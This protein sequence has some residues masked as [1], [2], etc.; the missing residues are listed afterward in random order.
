M[1]GWWRCQPSVF[2]EL[3][4]MKKMSF[5]SMTGN[6]KAIADEVFSVLPEDCS[7]LI[8]MEPF[9]GSGG[10]YC[11]L[12]KTFKEY[13]CSDIF[14]Y[15]VSFLQHKYPPEVLS[16]CYDKIQEK[17]DITN[18]KGD[19]YS[20][21]EWWNKKPEDSFEKDLAFIVLANGMLRFGPNGFNQSYGGRC[22]SK[23]EFISS[24]NYVRPNSFF[25]IQDFRHVDYSRADVIYFDPPYSGT[26]AMGGQK[27][28]YSWSQNEDEDLLGLIRISNRARQG[29]ILSTIE[30]S[31][32]Q[33]NLANFKTIKI[34]KKYKVTPWK[35]SAKDYQ[36]IIL[37]NL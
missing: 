15:V 16:E 20:F 36:E 35:F 17:Y 32:F 29:I 37:T 21:R 4:N 3:Q 6:K 2:S 9:F 19:Y 25:S 14:P 24:Y 26:G 27:G 30:D 28:I 1:E 31:F 23:Q 22:I 34:N 18:N 11:N 33:Q 8:Y 12:P 10:A 7:D 5:I 13:H